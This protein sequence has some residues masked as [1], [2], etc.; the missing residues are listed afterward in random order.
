MIGLTVSHYRILEKLGS[1]S[2]GVVYKAEDTRLNR[3]VALKFLPEDLS[4]DRHALA[5]IM[6]LLLN[7]AVILN[8]ETGL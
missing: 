4:R 6:R 2:M 3:P 1:G 7:N 8:E 5:L